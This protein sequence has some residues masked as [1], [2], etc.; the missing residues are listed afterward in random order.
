ML[1]WE[2]SLYNVRLL[3]S[4]QET[5]NMPKLDPKLSFAFLMYTPLCPQIGLFRLKSERLIS[6]TGTKHCL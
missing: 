3:F 5:E 1:L 4:H 6:S 2:D